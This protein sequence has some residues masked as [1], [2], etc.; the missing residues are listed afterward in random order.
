[1][2]SVSFTATANKKYRV[3]NIYVGIPIASARAILLAQGWTQE[4]LNDA[5]SVEE[6]HKWMRAHGEAA[7][8]PYVTKPSPGND[9]FHMGNIEMH[10]EYSYPNELVS[11]VW[12]QV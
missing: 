2:Q 11:R 12:R 5:M 1:M 3:G 8:I 9:L 10:L 7:D 6:T 4:H